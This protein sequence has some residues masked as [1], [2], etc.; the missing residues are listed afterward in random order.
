MVVNSTKLW[1]EVVNSDFQLLETFDA[2]V[3]NAHELWAS[4]NLLPVIQRSARQR[5]IY[6]TRESAS[7]TYTP[8]EELPH[9]YFNWTMT[10]KRDADVWFPYGRIV[11][12]KSNRPLTELKSQWLDAVRMKSKKVLWIVS[13]CHT[14]SHRELYVDQLRQHIDVDIYG[15][16]GNSSVDY[17]YLVNQYKFYLSFE[18]SLCDDYVTESFFR[19]LQN[20]LV[21]VVMGGANYS[22]LAPDHSYIDAT[23][24]TPKELAAYL[25]DLDSDDES[26]LR[27]FNW[28]ANYTVET[29]AGAMARRAFCHL[30]AK[31]HS[32]NP[33][34]FYPTLA[35]EMG[36]R[37]QC[38]NHNF[39]FFKSWFLNSTRDSNHLTYLT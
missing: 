37:S 3:F 13:K 9:G 17:A 31:L 10:Y 36:S 24:R 23:Q 12:S 16:C 18:N 7:Y 35:G 32:S 25:H 39:S 15:Q 2:V 4:I 28:K 1:Q 34:K 14:M 11:A 33:P 38:H 5:F 30:C 8:A 20:P 29:G 27:F 26:Y 19:A 6:F 21:P 22:C